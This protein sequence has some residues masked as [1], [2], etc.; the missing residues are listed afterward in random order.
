MRRGLLIASAFTLTTLAIACDDN[1]GVREAPVEVSSVDSIGPVYIDLDSAVNADQDS[2]V[3][4]I[5]SLTSVYY[6]T[7]ADPSYDDEDDDA[8]AFV[9]PYIVPDTLAFR[10]VSA[11][12]VAA[13]KK[14]K[15]FEYANDPAYWQEEKKEYSEGFID[16][17]FR[18]FQRPAVRNFLFVLFVLFVIY[19]IVRLVIS[20]N[21]LVF[22]KR[23]QKRS[24]KS[25]LADD[26][27][28][29]AASIDDLLRK[30]LAEKDQRGAVRYLYLKTLELLNR[31]GWIVYHPETTNHA[32]RAQVNRFAKGREFEFLCSVY[33]YVWYGEFAMN[34]QQFDKVLHNFTHFQNSLK[35]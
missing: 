18:F 4:A 27:E 31:K 29:N 22:S 6:D 25:E 33:E 30:A 5:D 34:E 24:D 10:E 12:D 13:L 17:F 14:K 20:N 28:L 11:P 1:S 15:E 2:S 23:S 19:I 32:Y 9:R 8:P 26:T 7:A 3:I 35:V 21:M 16:K